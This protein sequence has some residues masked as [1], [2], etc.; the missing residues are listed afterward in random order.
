MDAI[1]KLYSSDIV[2]IEPMG[3]EE[4]PAR[5]TGLDAIRRKNQWWYDNNE[6]HSAKVNGPFVGED[7][8]AVEY[9][10]ETTHKP[11]GRR[12]AMSEVGVYTVKDG[13]IVSEQF[14]YN[15]PGV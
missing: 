1:N 3:N 7:Q 2:S 9:A 6:V 10:Y 11:T 13:K 5:M 12:N 4:M 14:Y 15:A 8:F